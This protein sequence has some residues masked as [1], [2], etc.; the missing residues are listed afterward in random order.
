MGENVYIRDLVDFD[1]TMSTSRGNKDNED[2]SWSTVFKTREKSEDILSFGVLWKDLFLLYLLHD[3]NITERAELHSIIAAIQELRWL[4]LSISKRYNHSTHVVSIAKYQATTL[5][6]IRYVYNLQVH[7]FLYVHLDCEAIIAKFLGTPDSI[8]YSYRLSTM[9]SAQQHGVPMKYLIMVLK[10][11]QV[12]GCKLR[13]VIEIV[14]KYYGSM[15]EIHTFNQKLNQKKKLVKKLAKNHQ[16]FLASESV[17]KQIPPLVGP[18]LNKTEKDYEYD[19]EEGVQSAEHLKNRS[20]FSQ[21]QPRYFQ[22][23]K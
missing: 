22:P 11:M 16:A 17:I 2:P 18:G 12:T 13:S 21:H 23:P 15:I 9:F 7:K 4:Y 14:E 20:S 10:L 3:G 19:E 8:L 5:L 6:A 1:V